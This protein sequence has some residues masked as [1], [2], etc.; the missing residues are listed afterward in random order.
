MRQTA[1]IP[2]RALISIDTH[3]ASVTCMLTTALDT[4][5]QYELHRVCFQLTKRSMYIE[6]ELPWSDIP[7]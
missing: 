4:K 7:E 5:L 6:A 1:T 2:A 3:T